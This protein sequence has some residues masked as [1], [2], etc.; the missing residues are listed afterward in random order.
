MPPQM[1][2]SLFTNLQAVGAGLVA[3]GRLDPV[4]LKAIAKPER[5]PVILAPAFRIFL[6]L[7]LA[8]FYFDN[9]LKQNNAYEQRFARPF[10]G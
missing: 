5:F 3:S 8:R 7:P 4:L 1:T 9:M 6:R 2:R 10:A